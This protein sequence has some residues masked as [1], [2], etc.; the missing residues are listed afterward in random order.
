MNYRIKHHLIEVCGIA[1]FV[2][3]MYIFMITILSF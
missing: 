3:G 2:V 1:L